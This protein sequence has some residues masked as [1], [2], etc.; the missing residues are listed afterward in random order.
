VQKH[1]GSFWK[2]PGCCVGKH[3]VTHDERVL[4]PLGEF[5]HRQLPAND[6]ALTNEY[7]LD[8]LIV[9]PIGCRQ[10][11]HLPEEMLKI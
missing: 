6:P 10:L 4:C 9:H 2:A 8:P 5:F 1:V 3:L 7:K 11:V